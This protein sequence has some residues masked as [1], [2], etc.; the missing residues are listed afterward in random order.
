MFSVWN[1]KHLKFF[2]IKTKKQCFPMLGKPLFFIRNKKNVSNYEFETI[3]RNRI[4]SL[5]KI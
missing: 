1:R 2:F 4:R 3:E 5:E